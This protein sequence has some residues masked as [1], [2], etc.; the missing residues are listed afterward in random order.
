ME[1]LYKLNV[2]PL[3]ESFSISGVAFLYLFRKFFLPFSIFNSGE[4]FISVKRCSIGGPSIIFKRYAKVDKTFIKEQKYGDKAKMVK[5]IIGFDANSLYLSVLKNTLPTGFMIHRE[6]PSFKPKIIN[7]QSFDAICWMEYISKLENVK[8][9]HALFVGEV[10]VTSKNIPVDGYYTSTFGIVCMQY[11]G[12]FIHGHDCYKNKKYGR[13]DVHPFKKNEN[14]SFEDVYNNTLQNNYLI[15]KE[16]YIL[17]EI[18]ECE[19]E[20]ILKKDEN[21]QSIKKHL[22]GKKSNIPACSE[23]DLINA[24]KNEKIFGM[25]ECDIEVPQNKRKYFE[26]LTPIFKNVDIS[27]NDIGENM[28]KYCLD[29][30]LLKQPRKQLIGSY[31]GDKIWIM[32]PLAKWYLD[33]GL[34]IKKIY[35][36]LE[37]DKMENFSE[38]VDEIIKYRRLGDIDKKYEMIGGIFKLI[39]NSIYGKSILNK[40]NIHKTSYCFHDNS[41]KFI[42]SPHFMNL[43]EIGNGVSEIEMS[44]RTIKQNIPLVLGFSILNY[45]KGVLLS[46]FYDFIKKYIPDNCFELME[47][48]T[49]SLY[50]CLSDN[51]ENLVPN[52]KKKISTMIYVIGCQ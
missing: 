35:Q 2:D 5:K 4:L 33:K 26:E 29:N 3:K 22:K 40:N 23:S 43:N 42:R 15:T 11:H 10:K 32:S 30:D 31:F 19:W 39:G 28:K 45:A 52:E 44:S 49:D 16:G 48:D 8:I 51:L 9:F 7:S 18:W 50:M 21:A 36:F 20:N 6:Y 38:V 27:I 14:L 1:L 47:T 25:V 24:I 13:T 37:F 41:E 34:I 17:K 46:F 12:C